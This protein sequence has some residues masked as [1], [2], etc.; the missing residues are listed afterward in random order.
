MDQS[1][2]RHGQCRRAFPARYRPFVRT[3]V[4][5]AV[6]IAALCGGSAGNLPGTAVLADGSTDVLLA[7]TLVVDGDSRALHARA[8]SV[9]ELLAN[10]QVELGERDRVEPALTQC[11]SAGL[12]I[13]V[14][15]ITRRVVTETQAVPPPSRT[16]F[17]PR[18]ARAIELD[19]GRPG[20]RQ[21]RWEIWAANG[22]EISRKLLDSHLLR[23]PRSRLVVTGSGKAL[24]SRGGQPMIMEATGYDP[25]P[26]SCGRFASGRT[27]IGARATKGVAAVDPRLIPLGT[28]LYVEGYG[29]AVAADVGGAI[30][31]R[32][33]DLCFD[34][35]RQALSWGRRTVRVFVLD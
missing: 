10:E 28:R 4:A 26:I 6:F 35:Y 20:L 21:V 33:I 5:F 18:V 19:P 15:R 13:R 1:G 17:D 31:G 16:R 24:P 32:R 12:V 25:G 3:L 8:G 11:L 9:A 7:V 14:T 30:K 22:Q 2:E 29:P 27:A 23:Q 34:T